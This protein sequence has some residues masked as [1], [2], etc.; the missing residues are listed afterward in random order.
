MNEILSSS[1]NNG[2]RASN[3]K[4]RSDEKKD[5]PQCLFSISR[6]ETF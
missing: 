6:N 2:E 4:Y 1:K 5:R 3:S